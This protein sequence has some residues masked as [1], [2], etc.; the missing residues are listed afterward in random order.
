MKTYV[1]KIKGKDSGYPYFGARYY[2]DNIMMWLSVDPMSDKYPSMSPYMYCAGNPIRLVDPNGMEVEADEQSRNNIKNTLTKREAR[3]VRFDK[4]GVLDNK[5]LSKSKSTSENMN[6]L[7]A[8][9]KSEIVYSFHVT[10]KD[11]EGNAFYDNSATGGNYE[12]GVTEMP[13]A[14]SNPSPDNKVYILVGNNLGEKQQAMTTAHEAFG[15]AYFY[16][17]YRD[18]N[19]ASH[20]YKSEGSMYWDNGLQMN[21]FE[22]T[23]VPT[24]LPL[25]NQIKTVV[26]QAENNYDARKKK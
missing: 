5:R 2:S 25:E 18:V 13:N 6:A 17:I 21:V 8:L 15:H 23:K 11:H 7:K 22:V 10:D 1:C 19:K 3:F 20:T 16:E 26:K 12:R 14:E 4:N 9:A 24:N